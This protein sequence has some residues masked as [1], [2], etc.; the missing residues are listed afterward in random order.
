LDGQSVNQ[1]VGHLVNQS[2]NKSVS[3]IASRSAI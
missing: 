1:P 2:V 3:F